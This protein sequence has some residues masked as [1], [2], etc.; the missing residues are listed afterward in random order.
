[1]A[2]PGLHK[3]C[4]AARNALW[5]VSLLPLLDSYCL[6]KSVLQGDSLTRNR[7]I[8]LPEK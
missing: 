6:K 2:A 5:A 3:S 7:E 4:R 1:M 8:N